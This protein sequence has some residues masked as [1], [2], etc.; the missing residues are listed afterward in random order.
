MQ[1]VQ[2]AAP[3]LLPPLHHG[4]GGG[5]GVQTPIENLRSVSKGS[6]FHQGWWST[7]SKDLSDLQPTLEDP[8]PPGHTCDR[9][10]GLRSES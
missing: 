4:R 1:S 7:Q 10:S 9:V 8:E 3:A 5:I 6:Q 2:E